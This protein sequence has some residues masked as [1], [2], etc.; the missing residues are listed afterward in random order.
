[1]AAKIAAAA[2]RLVEAGRRQAIYEEAIREVVLAEPPDTFGITD[3][4]GLP[5][6]EIDFPEDLEA[7]RREI[8]PLLQALPPARTPAPAARPGPMA[9]RKSAREGR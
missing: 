2:W 1:M 8:F 9:Q 4:T 5:W 3:I 6:V 7:A